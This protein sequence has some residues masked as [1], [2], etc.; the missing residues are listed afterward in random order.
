VNTRVSNLDNYVTKD[1]TTVYFKIN[2]ATLTPDAK[3]DLD[4]LAQKA[5]NEKGYVVEVAGFADKTGPAAFN[6][7]LS[8]ERANAVIQYLEEQGNIPIH[9][10]LTPAGLGT[11][12]EAAANNTAAGRKLNRRVE[13]K[14]LVNQG[15]VGGASTAANTETGTPHQ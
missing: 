1:S 14:V 7:K 8:E 13:V 4:E 9:R 3:K 10:I 12:H 11:S 5:L 2:S 15:V 6:Q